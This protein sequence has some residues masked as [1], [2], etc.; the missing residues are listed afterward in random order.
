MEGS[1]VSENQSA[2]VEAEF[3]QLTGALATL[4]KLREEIGTWTE[5]ETESYDGDTLDRVLAHIASL[6][7]A[8]KS[9]KILLQ[10]KLQD[11]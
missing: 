8:Y 4:V 10:E 5:Q 1:G 6:E 2:A 3:Q 7:S 11:R 9:R